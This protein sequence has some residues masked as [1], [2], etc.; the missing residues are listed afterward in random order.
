MEIID[1]QSNDILTDKFKE[2]NL[3]E[4]DK[5]LSSEQYSYLKK[6][7]VNLFQLLVFVRKNLFKDE[8]HKI[9]LQIT[10]V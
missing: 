7:L 9:L 10:T 2:G 5:C 1:L 8:I 3:I 4:V 6:L